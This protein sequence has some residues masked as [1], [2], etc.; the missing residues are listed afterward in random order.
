MAGSPR[1]GHSLDVPS[2]IVLVLIFLILSFQ[3]LQRG[4]YRKKTKE[5]IA[6][7]I[8]LFI[9]TSTNRFSIIHSRPSTTTAAITFFP[10]CRRKKSTATHARKESKTK[11]DARALSSETT[12]EVGRAETGSRWAELGL[13]HSE[14]GCLWGRS[15]VCL[16]DPYAFDD[17]DDVRRDARA[18]CPQPRIITN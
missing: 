16:T 17:D 10:Y 12:P 1:S 3:P 2:P 15:S 4:T 18:L 8:V 13:R 5:G 7:V 9:P 11:E 6:L 14:I